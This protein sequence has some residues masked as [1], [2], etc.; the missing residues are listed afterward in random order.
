VTH[1][2]DD[3]GRMIAVGR[4]VRPQG[5]RGEVV[6]A[7]DTDYGQERFAAGSTLHVLL[8]GQLRSMAVVAGRP[9]DTRWVV[10]FEGVGSIDEAEALRGLEL[11]IPAAALRPLEGGRYWV[12]D[13]VGCVVTQPDGRQVGTVTQ[14]DLAA[15]V[16]MLRVAGEAG[17]ILLPFVGAI[18]RRVDVEGRTIVID[19][20]AGLLELNRPGAGSEPR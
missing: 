8:D 10:A 15:G 13:L 2:A 6:V 11:R 16:P 9:H 5:N 14:V 19:P 20:P 4:I 17:E 1:V 7:P 3:W 12:H 18:C